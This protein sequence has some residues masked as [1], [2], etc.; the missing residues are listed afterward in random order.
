MIEIY[1]CEDC[2]KYFTYVQIEEKEIC[3]EQEYGVSADFNTRTYKNVNCCPHCQ[4]TNYEECNDDEE[5]VKYLNRYVDKTPFGQKLQYNDLISKELVIVGGRGVWR[6]FEQDK[7]YEKEIGRK[8]AEKILR[9]IEQTGG[10]IND[11]IKVLNEEDK[12]NLHER[13]Y[14]IE[15]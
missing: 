14:Y 7:K 15:L 2:D 10:N 4:S 1:R 5:I 12:L 6:S 11:I 3:Y 8:Y 13:D 9:L